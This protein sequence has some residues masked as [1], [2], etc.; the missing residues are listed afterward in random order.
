VQLSGIN[1]NWLCANCQTVNSGKDQVCLLCLAVRGGGGMVGGLGGGFGIGPAGGGIG[2][3]GYGGYGGVGV[4]VREGDWT[5]S[6]M[7]LFNI[8][9]TFNKDVTILILRLGKHVK[10]VVPLK[11][12]QEV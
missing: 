11:L 2:G 12:M 10:V 8:L 4:G 5:C 1:G 3:F 6:S 7:C 9:I